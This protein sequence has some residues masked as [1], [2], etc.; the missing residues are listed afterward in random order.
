MFRVKQIAGIFLNVV[1]FGVLLFGPAGTL[2]W[3]RAW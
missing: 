3:P 1:I 2:S